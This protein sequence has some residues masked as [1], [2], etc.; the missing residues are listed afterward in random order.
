MQELDPHH[1]LSACTSIRGVTLQDVTQRL[2][3]HTL[4]AAVWSVIQQHLALHSSAPSSS[5]PSS[6]APSATTATGASGAD[7]LTSSLTHL[8][9]SQ[10]ATWQALTRAARGLR[11][12]SSLR[13]RFLLLPSRAD[14]TASQA[15]VTAPGEAVHATSASSA[16]GVAAP[17]GKQPLVAP[18]AGTDDLFFVDSKH[19]SIYIAVPP[20]SLAL[21]FHSPSDSTYSP[22][23]SA[24]P[25]LS[26]SSSSLL[27]HLLAA[28]VS[29]F[30][31]SPVS[32]PIAALLTCPPGS[33][34]L[35]LSALQLGA[36]RI[37]WAVRG[38]DGEENGSSDGSAG[39]TIGSIDDAEGG[40]SA[41][42]PTVLPAR[43]PQAATVWQQL[44]EAEHAG[45]PGQ[46]MFAADLPL[47]RC[48]PLRP[49]H[50]GEVVA[51]RDERGERGRGRGD[52]RRGQ[53]PLLRYGR[54]VRD[55]RAPAGQ[56]MCRVQVR[57]E[58][59]WCLIVPQGHVKACDVH[60][61]E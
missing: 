3:S 6:S 44:W 39:S 23:P 33:E 17:D 48:L 19:G 11:F 8:P 45:Q 24:L 53:Q 54:V 36:A 9:Q 34:G 1:P 57:G 55:V 2:Q 37:G 35:A 40:A 25:S 41:A 50:A 29:R 14:I 32:L 60:V 52:E 26:S 61:C 49:F 30:L 12:V 31:G 38:S 22:S 21:P 13:V 10:H 16:A 15:A 20:P 59:A 43:E 56:A 18:G 42:L 27:P 28:A 5:L 4:A 47:L 7:H 46:K 58:E 51:W